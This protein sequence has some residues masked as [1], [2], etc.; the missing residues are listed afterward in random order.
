GRGAGGRW[1]P[2]AETEWVNGNK[3]RLIGIILNGLQGE[4]EVNGRAYNDVMPQHGF[5]KDVEIA[6]ILTFV[7]QSFG[8]SAD[9]ISEAE[10][11]EV[12]NSNTAL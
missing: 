3:K 6:Q 1:P 8:N 10:V 11:A 4:I 7:R 2:I 12:R 5:L 9:P